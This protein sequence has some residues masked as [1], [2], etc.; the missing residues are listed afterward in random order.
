MNLNYKKSESAIA[1]PQI[2]TTSSKKV[3][4]I[5]KNIAEER[6]TDE[7][8][9]ETYIRYRYDEAKIPK[10]EYTQYQREMESREMRQVRADTDY[11]ALMVGVEL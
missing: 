9:G 10:A 7:L 6:R 4:Y 8:N 1:P 2:D 3:V 11:I 5:R